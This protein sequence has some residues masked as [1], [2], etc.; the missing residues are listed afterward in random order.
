MAVPIEAGR[1]R[2]ALGLIEHNQLNEA[3]E[4]IGPVVQG[5]R[6]TLPGR[7][8]PEPLEVSEVEG[9]LRVAIDDPD[10][11]DARFYVERAYYKLRTLR[12]AD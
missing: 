2:D 7:L 12:L 11:D 8:M 1:I 9:W 4:L 10:S 6:H 3:M 5:K